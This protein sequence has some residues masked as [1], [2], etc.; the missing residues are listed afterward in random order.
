MINLMREHQLA[1]DD[2]QVD[3]T[4]IKVLKEPDR[5]PTSDKWMW[6]T[7]GGPLV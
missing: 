1:H 6:V 2:L 5:S 7:Q 4:C 3:E